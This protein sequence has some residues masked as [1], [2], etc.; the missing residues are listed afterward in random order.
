M[1][2]FVIVETQKKKDLM[3]R[4]IFFNRDRGRRN[5]CITKEGTAY[6]TDLISI[7]R[8]AIKRALFFQPEILFSIFS[9]NSR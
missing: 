4:S 5:D 3:L 9:N 1:V 8:P 6:T 2:L 7:V